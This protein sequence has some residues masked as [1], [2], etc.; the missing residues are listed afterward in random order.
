MRLFWCIG[1]GILVTETEKEYVDYLADDIIFLYRDSYYHEQYDDG[2]TVECII[3]KTKYNSS[4]IAEY[5]LENNEGK[6]TDT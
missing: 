6:F 1:C 5:E 4:G 2:S 3:A